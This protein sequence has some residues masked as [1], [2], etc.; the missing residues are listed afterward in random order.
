M[1]VSVRG[2]YD[3]NVNLTQFDPQESLF[4]NVALGVTYDF[5]SPRTRISLN[6]GAGCYL[7]FRPRRSVY[8]RLR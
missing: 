1:S 5:G 6:S 4:T 3:D 8:R 7:L 2:G